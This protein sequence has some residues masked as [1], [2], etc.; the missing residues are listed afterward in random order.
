MTLTEACTLLS[1]CADHPIPL[2]IIA[3]GPLRQHAERGTAPPPP[4]ISG[5]L[6]LRAPAPAPAP[7]VRIDS[8]SATVAAGVRRNSHI[9]V[10]PG[11]P[12][13]ARALLLH[14]GPVP[15]AAAPAAAV[16]ELVRRGG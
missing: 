13:G 12:P 15:D 9:F 7:A 16:V 1:V 11:T 3:L 14:L 8:L 5:L 10:V 2:D 4:R 6:H